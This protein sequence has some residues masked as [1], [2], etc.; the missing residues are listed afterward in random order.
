MTK[1]FEEYLADIEKYGDT[2]P[3]PKSQTPPFKF[4]IAGPNNKVIELKEPIGLNYFCTDELDIVYIEDV[5]E[6]KQFTHDLNN[7]TFKL[8]LAEQVIYIDF[9]T[10]YYYLL[11][12]FNTLPQMKHC[13]KH[14]KL[15]IAL[16]NVDKS[17]IINKYTSDVNL[18]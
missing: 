10:D 2:F 17:D 1:T 9:N 7:K 6:N 4:K 13:Q 11:T 18:L 12:D 16:L 5:S 8:Y 14:K 15:T 3:T